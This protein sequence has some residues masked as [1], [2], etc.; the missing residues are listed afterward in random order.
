MLLLSFMVFL[1]VT[2]V[3]FEDRVSKLKRGCRISSLVLLA[4][5]LLVY[6]PLAGLVGFL[7][8]CAGCF[9]R[10]EII[11]PSKTLRRRWLMDILHEAGGQQDEVVLQ[12]VYAATVPVANQDFDERLAELRNAGWV[13]YRFDSK[14]VDGEWTRNKKIWELTLEGRHEL[15]HSKFNRR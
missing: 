6:A 14:Y 12:K 13:T 2:L 5:C 10:A 8:I 3:S 1:F 7:S 9:M 15:L 11:Y 4:S